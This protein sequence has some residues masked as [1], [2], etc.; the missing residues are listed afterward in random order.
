MLPIVARQAQ[1]RLT[2]SVRMIQRSRSIWTRYAVA[3]LSVAV[4][5]FARWALSSA[6]G[7]IYPFAPIFLAVIL[8]AWYGGFGPAVAAS[9]LGWALAFFTADSRTG[10]GHPF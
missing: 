1:P 8:A 6:F 5:A 4:A 2:A 9:L 10:N 7:G 3:V